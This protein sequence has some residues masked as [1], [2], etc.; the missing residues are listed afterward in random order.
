MQHSHHPYGYIMSLT[1]TVIIRFPLDMINNH[2]NESAVL[3]N[4][5]A[6]SNRH[7]T[8]MEPYHNQ[9]LVVLFQ[10]WATTRSRL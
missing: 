4:I 6:A 5:D 8:K 7:V 3:S 9:L 1:F 2:S 10:N